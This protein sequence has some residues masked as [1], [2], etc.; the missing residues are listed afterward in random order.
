M[1][2]W[3][4]RGNPQQY[5]VFYKLYDNRI[6]ADLVITNNI[7]LMVP[8]SSHSIVNSADVYINKQTEKQ[9]QT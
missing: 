8:N 4:G 3:R 1:D 9:I 6:Y 2:G 5:Y 7:R